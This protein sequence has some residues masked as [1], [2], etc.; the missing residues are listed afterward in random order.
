VL[1]TSLAGRKKRMAHWPPIRLNR[2]P[3]FVL[4]P[5]LLSSLLS[6]EA[7]F[8]QGPPAGA[9]FRL[10]DFEI[11]LA[12]GAIEVDGLLDESAWID[13]ARINLPYEWFP[14][15]NIPSPV[16]TEVFVTFDQENLYLAFR[17]YDPDPTS[18]R[19]NLADRDTPFQDD[20]VGFMI[21]PFNDERRGFQFRIN[22][23]GVQMDAIFSENEGY[24]DF[25]W[26]AIWDS[27][28]RITEEGYEVE[29]A[30]PFKSLR[31]PRSAEA[32]TW[33]FMAFRSLPREV[34]HRMRSHP[35]DQ[36]GD[37][38]YEPGVTGSWSVTPNLVF[39][40]TGNPDFSQVEADVGQLDVNN[41]FA[42]FFPERRPFFLEGADFFLTP[43][44][45]IFTRTVADPEAGAKLT[46][47]EGANALGFFLT[48][49][50]V[51]NLLFPGN[52]GS[53][54]T[55]LSDDVTA[56]VLRY[57][58][59]VGAGS[60]VGG[61]MTVREAEGY[62]NR[63]YGADAFV[64]LSATN[65]IQAQYLRSDTE[66]PSSVAANLDQREGAFGGDA[67]HLQ[68]MHR[69]RDWMATA[70]LE[71]LGADF[72]ADA[73]FIPR[74]DTRGGQA[75]VQKTWWA[76]QPGQWYSFMSAGILASRTEDLDG[77]LTDERIQLLGGYS[78][79]MQS[80]VN[81]ALAIRKELYAETL[82]EDLGAAFIGF[83]IRPSGMATPGFG[84]ELSETVDYAA[85]QE[86]TQLTAG[87]RAE[88]KL[89]RHLNLNLQHS[90]RRL[91]RDG[92]QA[93]TA[94]LSQMRAVYNL[95]VRTFFRAIVQY[96]SIRR[97]PEKYHPAI[98]RETS[99]LFTQFLFSYK[100]NPQTVL[101][102]GYSDNAEGMLTS[103]FARTDLTRNQKTFF[104]KLGYAWRP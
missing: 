29:V 86:G 11:A 20:H 62:H 55:S 32:R 73:G 80:N 30:I 66:Y 51:N 19:A 87:P 15:D 74:V 5:L 68:F 101:F 36:S 69:S 81:V 59:D 6:P 93:F 38:E 100:V 79:P 41:R 104:L 102:L 34:R 3:G 21:D 103:D 61:L 12:T 4:F 85:G 77:N 43:L 7:A 98:N 52:Q 14:G 90:Y 48:Q 23:L 46:G 1:V 9:G 28:G 39:N 64:R 10:A 22:P 70:N 78:G 24:E 91:A 82:F 57:R 65:T 95:N 97:N 54:S 96:Q 60:T 67:Y 37:G 25:S 94:N 75:L 13:A 31:F 88:L 76:P 92:D 50:R 99:S 84:S 18:V 27:D 26:D 17:A 8:A 72:R 2:F 16:E 71:Q 83:E 56:G 42:L 45:V 47:K 44:N 49:D 89:G 53:A 40:G 58:R 63:V 35:T 33:G